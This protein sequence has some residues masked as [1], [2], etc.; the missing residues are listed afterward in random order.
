[1]FQIIINQAG[2]SLGEIEAINNLFSNYYI[3]ENI[4][5]YDYEFASIL[6]IQFIK[7]KNL[8][9]FDFISIEKWSI[10]IEII[11]NIKKEGG[12]RA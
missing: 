10:L 6:E 11:K 8:E 5:D 2:L 7:D 3:T 4:I 9:F 1:L 12:E